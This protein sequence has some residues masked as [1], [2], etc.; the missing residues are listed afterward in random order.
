MQ[1]A[2][3]METLGRPS[4]ES[5]RRGKKR[6]FKPSGQSISL[7]SKPL[8]STTASKPICMGSRKAQAAVSAGRNSTVMGVKAIQTMELVTVC[9]SRPKN[10]LPWKGWSLRLYRKKQMGIRQSMET[11]HCTGQRL[12]SRMV[13]DK[14]DLVLAV[15]V[16]MPQCAPTTPSS[17][18][19]Q[20][21]SKA[22]MTQ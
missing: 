10:S 21:W 12:S 16:Q 22:S 8:M 3:W 7:I 20:G 4:S 11:P 17:G 14:R 15:H 18:R 9:N 5:W 2:T 6:R 13:P 1:Q 19:F